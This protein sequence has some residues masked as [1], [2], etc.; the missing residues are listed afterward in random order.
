MVEHLKSCE[1]KFRPAS[2]SG[3]K[4]NLPELP[5]ETARQLCTIRAMP[6]DD[7][8]PDSD[9]EA[10]LQRVR[11]RNSGDG[12][13]GARR[14]V[15]GALSDSACVFPSGGGSLVLCSIAR[16]ASTNHPNRP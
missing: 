3:L 15:T 14:D 5:P 12:F 1:A 2:K 4:R 11:R 9:S 7:S 10:I 8:L 13:W 16:C 6:A